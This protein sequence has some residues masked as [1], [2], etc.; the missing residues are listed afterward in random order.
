MASLNF[1][2]QFEEPSAPVTAQRHQEYLPLSYRLGVPGRLLV[3]IISGFLV[4]IIASG[5]HRMGAAENIP[6]GLFLSFM[7]IGMSAWA[8]RSRS[9]VFGAG[10]H[11]LSSSAMAWL[12]AFPG[13]AG[14]VLVP[15]GGK[16]VFLSFFGMHAGYIWLY[17]LIVLQLV[18]LVL[19]QRWFTVAGSL[20]A[21][22][23]VQQ[24]ASELKRPAEVH[25]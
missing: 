4:A 24:Y 13:P 23:A 5:T 8:A 11:L 22:T 2:E 20:Q 12:M 6:Y 25:R 10:F 17:G 19:P 9:G 3:S 16:G 1:Q 21:K 14:D 7:L 18:M 15:V